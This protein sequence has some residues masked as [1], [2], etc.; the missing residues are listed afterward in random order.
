[1]LITTVRVMLLLPVME[2]TCCET[3]IKDHGMD[4][5]SHRTDTCDDGGGGHGDSESNDDDES[6]DDDDNDDVYGERSAGF[7]SRARASRTS[8]A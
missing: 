4:G 5:D 7:W 2:Q 1:M 3:C 6:D 8:R